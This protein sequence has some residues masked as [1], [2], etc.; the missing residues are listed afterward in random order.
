MSSAWFAS[1]LWDAPD[2]LD[3]PILDLTIGVHGRYH[4]WSKRC[5]LSK[6]I[7]LSSWCMVVL[8]FYVLLGLVLLLWYLSCFH[9]IVSIHHHCRWNAATFSDFKC[10]LLSCENGEGKLFIT[11]NTPTYVLSTNN[12]AFALSMLWDVTLPTLNVTIGYLL[13]I[14]AESYL[15]LPHQILIMLINYLSFRIVSIETDINIEADEA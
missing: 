7:R 4:V 6:D 9:D 2:I 14:W 13:G 11:I 5:S 12:V 3:I 8:F 1:H 10:S 15:L